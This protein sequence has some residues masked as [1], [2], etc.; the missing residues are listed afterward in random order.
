MRRRII[1]SRRYCQVQEA[2]LFFWVAMPG[3][4]NGFSVVGIPKGSCL[5]ASHVRIILKELSYLVTSVADP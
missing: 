3:G 4:T 1:S 2:L 5:G